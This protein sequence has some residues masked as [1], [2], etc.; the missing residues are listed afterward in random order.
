MK[1]KLLL[2]LIAVCSVMFGLMA[3][4]KT[5]TGTVT[6]AD[7]A[8][9]A[10]ATVVV[11]GTSIGTTTD[12]AGHY[13]IAAPSDGKLNVSFIGYEDQTVAIANKTVIDIQMSESNTAIDDV[14]VMGYGSGRKIGT[15]IGSVDQVKADKIENR[16]SLNIMDALQ[17]QVAGLQIS[18]S[19]GEL[20][21]ASTI[22]LHGMGSLGTDDT[23]LILL[24]GAPI[25]VGALMAMNQNDF[26]SISVLKDASATSIYG[27]RASNGVIYITS[28][29][30]SRGSEDVDVTLR[31]S[32]SMSNLP[33]LKMKRMNTSQL[34]DFQTK[35]L[36]AA[37]GMDYTDPDTYD[38]L[39]NYLNNALGIDDPTV[40]TDWL[41]LLTNKNAPM[42]QIDLSVAGGSQ[43]TSYYFSA[44][45][46]DQE[47]VYPGSERTRYTFRADVDTRAA[48]WLKL[49]MNLSLGYA[50][51]ST[52]STAETAG[53]LYTSNP[54]FA[55]FMIPSYQPAFDEDGNRLDFLHIYGDANPLINPDYNPMNNNRLQLNGATFV[56]IAPV[57]G[58]TFRSQLS[59]TAF[60]YRYHEHFSPLWP[61]QGTGL[62]TGT[63]RVTE[64]FQ[65]SYEWTWTNTAEYMFD[66][67]HDHHFVFLLGHESI[68]GS[69]ESFSVSTKGHS[70]DK[71]MILNQ[72]TDNNGL[73]SYSTSEYAFNSVFGRMEYNYD[74]RY[75]LDFS[76]RNDASSRF[77]IN[78]RNGLFWSLGAMWNL[79]NEKF[80]K[81]NRTISDAAFK[82]SYGT[83]GNANIG[84]Y[85]QYAYLTSGTPY[86]GVRS[87]ILSNVGDPNLEWEEQS[88]LSIAA[89]IGLFKKL[90]LEVEWYRRET[91]NM[92]MSIPKALSSGVS[93]V[94]GNVGAMR[95]AG[96]DISL[97]YDIFSNKDWFVNFY[98]TFNYNRN[99]I[100]RLWEPGLEE[101]V[102]GDE[103]RY[104][105]GRAFPDWYM[106]EWRGVDPET[107]YG[108]WTAEDGGI[109]NY[110]EEA[111][112][113]DL[114][115]TALPPYTGG[116]G[117]NVTWKGLT[118]SADFSWAAKGYLF[119]NNKY[120]MAN[121]YFLGYGQITDVLDYWEKPGDNARYPSLEYQ[122]YVETGQQFDSS[123][124]EDASY[125]RL[126]NI[127]LSYTLPSTLLKKSGFIKGAKVYVGAR[128]LC[129]VTG[130][131]GMDPE[132]VEQ[133]F[134][135]DVYPNTRQWT[136]GVEL[137]F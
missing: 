36:G 31:A 110:F 72:G 70:N 28:K 54:V 69:G 45:Y 109:T 8:P 42:Y 32:Y 108:Q 100:L 123:L 52:T 55:A 115:K 34:L 19:N 137:K 98:A 61:S 71:F 78:S 38:F 46:S 117:L 114:N 129:T 101:A 65:R 120:F 17:G 124:L 88:T 24:D 56:E 43:K 133:I 47:G 66:V 136:F 10:G 25:G 6:G 128:N 21:T 3:Q 2:S 35:Y 48:K 53:S 40:D 11:E 107:G 132:V 121:S 75:F 119:N 97:S 125:L 82:I 116:F 27:A 76:M 18:T 94:T 95:N 7:G 130:Y 51:A 59:A 63:G 105:V 92:L 87:W 12:I 113:V 127:Q 118:L 86:N 41:S 112:L 90:N 104:K 26:A 85:E 22:R 126:K 16:P 5:V 29:K 93:S 1:K 68:Y 67:A 62:P 9:I 77:G 134:D 60:D 64:S 84:N 33:A 106:P 79:K 83:Q 73:P 103:M 57:K 49:G 4:N 102:Y 96:I 37:N 30:G 13:S 14:V 91:D 20:N 111:A 23:P 50:K 74:S 89:K 81:H 122:A 15:V 99:Q 44:N 131:T 58:L 135:T 39:Y 80:L